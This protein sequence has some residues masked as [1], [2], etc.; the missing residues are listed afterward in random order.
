MQATYLAAGAG[1]SNS[2]GYKTSAG[3]P[4]SQADAR[5]DDIY[6]N[7][8]ICFPHGCSLQ[9]HSVQQGGTDIPA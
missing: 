2:T 4:H 7:G 1:P 8:V 6:P 9:E 5:V 3:L